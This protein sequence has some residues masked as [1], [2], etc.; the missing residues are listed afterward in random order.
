MKRWIAA[1]FALAVLTGFASAKEQEA[2][3]TTNFAAAK[4]LAKKTNKIMF[5]EFTGSDWCSACMMFKAEILTKKPFL[6][7]AKKHLILVEI[8]FPNNKPQMPAQ[9]KFNEAL[10]QQYEVEAF[11]TVLLI[12]GDG[13]VLARLEYQ[14]GGAEK[15]VEYIKDALKK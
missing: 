13:K 9:R 3:W 4:Q 2:T 5:V 7:Y 10:A 11:P 14:E 12:N 1:V 8:D 15:Y 6:D